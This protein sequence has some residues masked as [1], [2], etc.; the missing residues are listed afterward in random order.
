IPRAQNISADAMTT[1]GSMLRIPIG[2]NDMPFFVE[3]LH[4]PACDVPE[5]CLACE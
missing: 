4:Q 3:N 5:Y 2:N 1:M